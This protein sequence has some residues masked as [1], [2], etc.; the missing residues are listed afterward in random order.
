[1]NYYY[2]TESESKGVLHFNEQDWPPGTKEL[3]AAVVFCR[4]LLPP[5]GQFVVQAQL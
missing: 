5:S 1:M 4:S 2:A 3:F